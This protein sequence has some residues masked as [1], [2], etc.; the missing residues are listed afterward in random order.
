[1]KVAMISTV[2]E[3]WALYN[4]IQPASSLTQGSDYYLFKE[5]IRPMWEDPKNINGGRWH[6]K[7]FEHERSDKFV[8]NPSNKSGTEVD[9]AEKEQQQKSKQHTKEKL[10][11]HWLELMMAVVGEQFAE[12]GP[13]I[14]GVV[15]NI[16][17]KGD[18]IAI[19]TR[20]AALEN[21]NMQIGLILKAKLGIP[22]SDWIRYEQHESKKVMLEIPAKEKKP[23]P[24]KKCPSA[25]PKDHLS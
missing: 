19:W 18:K 14:C 21:E 17:N 11:N 20:D 8:K 22:D 6:V 2:E 15:V 24:P 10:D 16:R 23:Y 25:S 12:L 4:F 5:G 9:I 3:F 7:G 1:M 13:Y